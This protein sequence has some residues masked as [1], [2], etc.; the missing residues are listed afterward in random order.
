[1]TNWEETP[2]WARCVHLM[3]A[4]RGNWNGGRGNTSLMMLYEEL[5]AAHIEG[6]ADPGWLGAVKAN[7]D[8]FDGYFRDGRVFR[9]GQRYF[10][11]DVAEAVGIPKSPGDPE[12]LV[13]GSGNLAAMLGAKPVK[14]GAWFGNYNEQPVPGTDAPELDECPS[15]DCMS[16]D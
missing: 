6:L 9:D 12:G 14:Q 1:M 2:H 10:P 15:A 11:E 4:L 7:A 8:Y 3:K 16:H 5:G 13:S